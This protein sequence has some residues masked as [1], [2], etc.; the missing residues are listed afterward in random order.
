[1]RSLFLL[2]LA[3]LLLAGTAFADKH[4]QVT[5]QAWIDKVGCSPSSHGL[6]IVKPF[7]KVNLKAIDGKI[8]EVGFRRQ[9][10]GVGY[11]GQSYVYQWQNQAAAKKY[12]QDYF[13]FEVP[14]S[15]DYHNA[16]LTG[17]FYVK[18]DKNTFYWIKTTG[19]KDF[20]FDNNAYRNVQRQKSS[21]YSW[22][23]DPSTAVPTQKKNGFGLYYNPN[24]L[25]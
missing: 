21:P 22:D 14:V 13:G 9:E 23:W 20:A 18:T 24:Q 1:M 6:C 3:G 8:T 10:K 5:N 11:Q 4:V 25:K 19:P 12:G 7:I 16:T 15:S 2:P 17:S